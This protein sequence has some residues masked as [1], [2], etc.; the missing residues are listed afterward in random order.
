MALLQWRYWVERQSTRREIPIGD[1]LCLVQ[2]AP[3]KDQPESPSWKA[4][5]DNAGLN[6]H[7]DL[8]LTIIKHES[9]VVHVPGNTCRLLFRG[10]GIFPALLFPA[11]FSRYCGQQILFGIIPV[12]RHDPGWET[13]PFADTTRHRRPVDAPW[14]SANFLLLGKALILQREFLRRGGFAQHSAPK[15]LVG[16][17]KPTLRRTSISSCGIKGCLKIHLIESQTWESPCTSRGGPK[18]H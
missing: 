9:V 11:P 8:K 5:R 4:A 7:R 12:H 1:E 6:F 17:Q 2:H 15:A 18:I 13:I 10:N 16:G 14:Y 3:F